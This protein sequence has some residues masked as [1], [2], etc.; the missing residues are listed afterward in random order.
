M[1]PLLGLGSEENGALLIV[2]WIAWLLHG[3]MGG[4]LSQRMY[5]VGMACLNMV[6]ALAWFGVNLLSVGLHSYGFI[7]GIA[8]G[9][10]LFCAVE[11]GL[12]AFLYARHRHA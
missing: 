4:Y 3:R 8:A 6:V 5:A 12:I 9:L 2:L 10:A 7:S 11:C 1:G